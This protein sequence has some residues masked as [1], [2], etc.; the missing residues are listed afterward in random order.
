MITRDELELMNSEYTS[1]LKKYGDNEKSLGWNKPKQGLRFEI[2]LRMIKNK[3][4]SKSTKKLRLLD[5][6][7]GLAHF[8]QYLKK[9]NFDVNYVGADANSDFIKHCRKKYPNEKFYNEIIEDHFYDANIICASGVFNRKFDK[10]LEIIK[11]F[12]TNS[13]KSDAEV[14]VVNFLHVSALQK[15]PNNFYTSL[16]DIESVIDRNHI[17]GFEIDGVSL[18]GEVTVGFYK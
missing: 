2:M 14:V 4:Q 16:A 13:Q 3:Y 15:Y 10:S 6:G 12:L 11:S 18:P 17:N 7:C 9:N 5:V 1:L 8:F